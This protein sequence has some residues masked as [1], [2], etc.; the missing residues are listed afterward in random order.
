MV[1]IYIK[2]IYGHSRWH[3]FYIL[4]KNFIVE[5]D[6]YIDDIFD[7]DELEKLYSFTFKGVGHGTTAMEMG[8]ILGSDYYEYMGQSP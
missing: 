5:R 3:H 1:D 8:E 2:F 6:D 7:L 4:L